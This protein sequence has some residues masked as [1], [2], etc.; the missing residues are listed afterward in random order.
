MKCVKVILCH[1]V[2]LDVQLM[3][4]LFEEKIM[5]RSPDIYTFFFLKSADFKIC[6]VFIGIAT[7]WKLHIRLF[8]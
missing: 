4:F 5:Y 1:I 2:T 6:N 7:S 8:F 3:I